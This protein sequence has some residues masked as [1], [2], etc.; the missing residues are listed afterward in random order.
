MGATNVQ[1]TAWLT[2]Q[3]NLLEFFFLCS[4]LSAT[5]KLQ[6]TTFNTPSPNTFSPTFSTLS[7]HNH[8]D[9]TTS[10]PEED[11]TESVDTTTESY[12][13]PPTKPAE[14]F[15][16]NTLQGTEL[17]TDPMPL[18]INDT[19]DVRFRKVIRVTTKKKIDGKFSC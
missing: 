14:N 12:N 15:T 11:F 5:D 1:C 8:I 3:G 16:R 18:S 2:A 9:A 7:A 4:I 19:E 13:F 17:P 10:L 6:P